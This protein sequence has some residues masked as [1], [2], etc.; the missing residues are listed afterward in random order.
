VGISSYIAHYQQL[1][2]ETY[3]VSPIIFATIYILSIPI[4]YISF[5]KVVSELI[6]LRRKYGS[7]IAHHAKSEKRLL[8]WLAVLVLDY[9][10]PYVYVAIFGKN[11]P[12]WLCIALIIV[13]LL[14]G[15]GLLGKL[16]KRSTL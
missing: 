1:A 13:L 11:L 7:G 9:L 8:F 3:H 12:T 4:F 15:Y 5:Y 14:M 6:K 2:V 16:Y 10:A